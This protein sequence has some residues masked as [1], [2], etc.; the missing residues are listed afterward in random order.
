MTTKNDQVLYIYLLEYDI[1][2]VTATDSHKKAKVKQLG[3]FCVHSKAI[4][5]QFAS[6]C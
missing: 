5:P 2:Y 6:Q 4:K 3:W 1:C